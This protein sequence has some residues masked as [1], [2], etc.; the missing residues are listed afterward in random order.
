MAEAE[1]GEAMTGMATGVVVVVIDVE[2]VA[3]MVETEG[4]EVIVT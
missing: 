3:A 1:E 4:M 2:V